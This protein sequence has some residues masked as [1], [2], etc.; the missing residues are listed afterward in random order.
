[1]RI[2]SISAL[3]ALEHIAEYRF[4][5]ADQLVR[6]GGSRTT[7]RSMSNL[8]KQLCERDRLIGQ[9]HFGVHPKLGKFKTIHFLT[10]KGARLLESRNFQK[11]IKFPKSNIT[12]FHR[13]YFHRLVCLD[14]EISFK[15]WIKQNGYECPMFERYFDPVDGLRSKTEITMSNEGTLIPDAVTLYKTGERNFCFLLEVSMGKDAKR[16]IEQLYIHIKAL[17][18]GSPSKTFNIPHGHFVACLFE[19]ESCMKSVMQHMQKDQRL[20]LSLKKHFLFACKLEQEA[21]FRDLA[22]FLW[23]RQ[24][25]V[26]YGL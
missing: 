13:D 8:L 10:H 22:W 23:D 6:L 24:K 20:H 1:M 14:F 15:Q 21:T 5:T 11:P 16:V 4:L 17:E 25:Q 7:V 26:F 18:D 19:H 2:L 3:V 12:L 9:A